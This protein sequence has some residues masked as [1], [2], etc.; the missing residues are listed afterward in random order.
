MRKK[1]LLLRKLLT[2][3]SQIPCQSEIKCRDLDK[4]SKRMLAT[5]WMD[6]TIRDKA[7]RCIF[8][9]ILGLN[10]SN[11]HLPAFG[12][13]QFAGIY[14]RFFRSCVLHGIHSCFPRRAVRVL[15]VFHDK[16]EQST[17]EFFPWHCIYAIEEQSDR[18]SFT[19][20]EISFIDSD[21]RE[22]EGCV[23]SHLIQLTDLIMGISSHCM[24]SVSRNQSRT[25]VAKKF[26]PLLQ[27][28]MATP[29]NTNSSYGYT[30]KY[31]ISFFPRRRLSA[32][33]LLDPRKRYLS[34]FYKQ[35]PL[36]LKDHLSNQTTLF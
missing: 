18:I 31:M 26:M 27:R 13:D 4:A 24:D 36:L 3:R 32:K 23:E 17:H 10:L 1:G 35:R 16:G 12:D 5:K 14:N 19:S 6:I 21:H 34:G 29:G 15:N 20:R 9:D 25:T 7:D 33:D 8:F 22:A 11:L 30:N 28:M 2:P